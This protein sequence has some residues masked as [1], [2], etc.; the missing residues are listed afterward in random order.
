MSIRTLFYR[1][2]RL[3]LFKQINFLGGISF[4]AWNQSVQVS[5]N[6][7]WSKEIRISIIEDEGLWEV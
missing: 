3:M 2:I 7:S 6:E 5:N 4:K 1:E